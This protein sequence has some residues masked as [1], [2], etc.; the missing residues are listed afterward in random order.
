MFLRTSFQYGCSN[1]LS[2]SWKRSDSNAREFSPWLRCILPRHHFIQ[3]SLTSNS[4]LLS[5]NSL[6]L[7]LIP[8]HFL[9]SFILVSFFYISNLFFSDFLGLSTFSH[10]VTLLT[11][12][13]LLTFPDFVGGSF[14]RWL[15][16]NEVYDDFSFLSKK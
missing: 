6:I 5:F 12:F 7:S 16:I 15:S 10:S 9:L 1:Y 13:I 14:S 8:I 3:R 11:F 4:I 2:G